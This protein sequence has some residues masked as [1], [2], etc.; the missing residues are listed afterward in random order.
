MV[1]EEFKDEGPAALLICADFFSYHR[2]IIDELETRGL[3]VEWWSDRISDTSIY[4]LLLRGMPRVVAW[5]ST[6][7]FIRRLDRLN[8][9]QVREVLVVKGEGLSPAA[10]K[11]MRAAMP[12]ASFHL[13]LWDGIDNVRGATAISRLFD[14]VA[15]F[16]PDDARRFGWRHRPLF[17][18]N[19]ES[20]IAMSGVPRIYDWIFIGS[21]HSDRYSVLRRLV[22]SNVQCR[23]FVYGFIPGKLVWWLRHVADWR[24]L[25]PGQIR[26]S[27]TP[28]SPESVQKI[29][30]QAK[31][32]VDIEHPRQRGL[33]MRTIETL[34]SHRKLITT[35]A[36]IRET[37]L[38][39][40]SRVCVIDRK[41]PTIPV[42]FLET[43][44]RPLPLAVRERYSL[45]RWVDDVLGRTPH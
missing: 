38:Y 15:T 45:K 8:T 29:A 34:M 27:M 16:D 41:A 7:G 2:S 12:A 36:R 25:R 30:D 1:T 13:Y 21:L 17:A 18:R 43:D 19:A 10:V 5:L 23:S 42:D 14:T 26:V 22:F 39:H 6:G 24:L 44:F 28:L 40:E 11:C 32:V 3:R 35:N 4:K 33:T 20:A 31:A 37:D 9:Q